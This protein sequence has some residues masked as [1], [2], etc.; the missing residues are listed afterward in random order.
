MDA[1]ASAVPGPT[2]GD[3]RD[4][5]G[6]Y[7]DIRPSHHLPTIEVRVADAALTPDDTLMLA[8]VVRALTATA[9]QCIRAGE[10]APRPAPEVLRAACWRAARDGLAGT[11]IDPLTGHLAAQTTLIEKLLHTI[12]PALRQHD[13]LDHTREQWQRLRTEGTGADRQRAAYRQRSSTPDV[14]DY[15]ISATCP[16]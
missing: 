2:A 13:D 7:W 9:L 8:A 12:A 5:V 15:L 4:D 16:Q 3:R 14:V 11:G 10:P 1:Q 6:L